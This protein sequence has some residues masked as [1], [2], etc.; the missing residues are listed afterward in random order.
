MSQNSP[1]SPNKSSIW[2]IRCGSSGPALVAVRVAVGHS[3]EAELKTGVSGYVVG[4]EILLCGVQRRE[5]LGLSPGGPEKDRVDKTMAIGWI[6]F[7]SGSAAPPIKSKCYHVRI[8]P[9]QVK[10]RAVRTSGV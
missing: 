5:K 6:K 3:Q 4:N 9:C 10:P 8:S 2:A 7:K 1:L